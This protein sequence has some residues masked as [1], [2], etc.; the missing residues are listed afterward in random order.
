MPTSWLC[1]CRVG[2]ACGVGFQRWEVGI[3]TL[4]VRLVSS[5]T[6]RN[7][8]HALHSRSVPRSVHWSAD[9]VRGRAGRGTRVARLHSTATSAAAQLQFAAHLS[10]W[11]SSQGMGSGDLTGL[12]IERFLAARRADYTSH[13]SLQALEP[14]LGY[15]RREDVGASGSA[16]GAVVAGRGVAGSL[17]RVPDRRT[18]SERSRGPRVLALGHS[19]RRRPD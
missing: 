12:V 1:R 7:Q 8:N 18:W 19:L 5:P 2:I 10:R 17:W 9:E 3:I 6:G 4:R 14:T 16:A 11:L 15:L 13:Y